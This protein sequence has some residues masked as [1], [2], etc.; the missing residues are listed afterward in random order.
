M[1]T[2]KLKIILGSTREGRFSEVASQWAKA[3]ADKHPEFE[4]EVLDLRDFA[5]PFFDQMETP[6]SKK[7]PY[8]NPAVAAWTAKIAEGDVFLV[9][10]PEYNRSAP[11][12]LKNALDWV[13]PEWNKKAI[14][15]VGYGSVG[16]ARSIEHLRL[17]A[18]EQQMV[19]VR[20]SVNINAPWMLRD[21]AGALKAG[22]LDEHEY[23]AKSM[24]EQLK[25][26]GAATKAMR[27]K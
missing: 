17:M 15:Y 22:V 11:G 5:L 8:A 14:G 10:A 23:A 2:L 19:P 13:Y 4:T 21:E 9:I 6:S 18:I 1:N 12:V 26:W 20:Q 7:A 3:Q 27:Q 25:E 24:F 16:G